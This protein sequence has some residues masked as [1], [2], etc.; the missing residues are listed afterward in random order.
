MNFPDFLD[1]MHEHSKIENVYNEVLA[2]FKGHDPRNTGT[3]PVKDLRHILLEWGEKLSPKEGK[4]PPLIETSLDS[5]SPRS[6]R[7]IAHQV[8]SR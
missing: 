5:F 8:F 2:A 7:M 6:I 1:V 3:I 4:T